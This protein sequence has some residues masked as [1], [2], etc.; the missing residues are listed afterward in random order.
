[1]LPLLL[2]LTAPAGNSW[3]TVK[4]RVVAAGTT[5]CLTLA[6]ALAAHFALRQGTPT[7]AGGVLSP[8]M[9]G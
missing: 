3:D 6:L 9:S 4:L 1:M 7:T 8:Q 5:F 2:S